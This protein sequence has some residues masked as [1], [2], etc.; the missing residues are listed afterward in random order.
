[1]CVCVTEGDGS[2]VPVSCLL[3]SRSG[4]YTVQVHFTGGYWPRCGSSTQ[5]PDHRSFTSVV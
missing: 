3:Y 2:S 5:L 4:N 1:M